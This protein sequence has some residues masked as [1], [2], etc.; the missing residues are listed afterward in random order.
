MQD[1]AFAAGLPRESM[2]LIDLH[3]HS[4]HS[5]GSLSP[6]ALVA[7]ARERGV[8][9]LALTD[10]DSV[11]G[12]PEAQAAAAGTELA[13]V[14]GLELS[15][16]WR[17]QNVHVVGLNVDIR[18]P[19]LTVALAVQAGAR[20]RRALQIAERLDARL[21]I[22]TADEGSYA[23]AL[24]LAGHPDTISRSHFARWL[25]D[26][27]RITS[28]Q[29]AFDRY[30]GQGK[31]ADVPIPWMDM[32]TAISLIREAGGH[33]V[34]AHPGRY[35]MSR[36]RLRELIAEFKV[37]GGE[38]LEVATATEKPDIV[39]Y[40]GELCRQHGLAASQGSDY[41]GGHMPWIDLGRFPPLP[42]GC[43][44]VWRLWEDRAGA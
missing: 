33:A 25:L 40:L 18:N 10:H 27:K 2:P 38:A 43:Q 22:E 19:A 31:A 37:S 12:V 42:E 23:G 15:T 26:T 34:L 44:P 24:A 3:S 17:K 1:L 28:L 13:V 16:L 6:S 29:Q 4:H 20:G 30:L 8:S 32:P 36:T 41:H 21:R 5:D 39:R 14:P 35:A 9:M 7:R 11:Q